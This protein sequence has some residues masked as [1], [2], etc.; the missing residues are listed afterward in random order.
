MLHPKRPTRSGRRIDARAS[1]AVE[2]ESSGSEDDDDIVLSLSGRGRRARYAFES[3]GSRRAQRGWDEY[4]DSIT[5]FLPLNPRRDKRGGRAAAAA[6]AA[7]GSRVD[8]V[9]G[10]SSRVQVAQ[11]LREIA[12]RMQAFVLDSDTIEY[13]PG[14]DRSGMYPADG[15]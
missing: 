13:D 7:H 11:S 5:D 2:D 10:P 14:A 9:G 3:S 4:D 12:Q 15:H 6:A 8:D 1:W